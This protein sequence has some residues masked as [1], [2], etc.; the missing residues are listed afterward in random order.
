M[1]G[2]SA[3]T[4]TSRACAARSMVIS[5]RMELMVTVEAPGLH[6][7]DLDLVLTPVRLPRVTI[8]PR[9]R[10]IPIHP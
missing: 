2:R 1:D 8:R 4:V 3:V 10:G 6:A 7:S 5:S 9:T